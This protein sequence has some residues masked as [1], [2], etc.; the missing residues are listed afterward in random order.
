MLGCFGGHCYRLHYDPLFDQFFK[1]FELQYSMVAAAVDTEAG[2]QAFVA[3]GDMLGE[4]G[5]K[6]RYR[7]VP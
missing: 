3:V 7:P 6:L 4:E 1:V 5:E 2:Y